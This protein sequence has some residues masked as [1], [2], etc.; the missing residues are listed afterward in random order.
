MPLGGE[1][2]GF[3]GA[4]LAGLVT[5]LSAI[6]TGAVPD[7][8]MM[9]MTGTDDYATPRNVGHF[10]LVID[11]DRFVGRAT[12]EVIMAQYLAALRASPS[13]PGVQTLAPGD[14]EWRTEAD[15]LVEGI[16]VDG[17]TAAVLG[18]A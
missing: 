4:G 13:Q 6:L 15:R 14:R 11:P 8:D 12:Y 9:P 17:D 16:P 10:C 7:P 2:F 1:G 3:K 5:V 18:L